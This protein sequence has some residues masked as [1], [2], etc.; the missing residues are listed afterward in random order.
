DVRLFL[1]AV[2]RFLTDG[3]NEAQAAVDIVLTLRRKGKDLLGIVVLR[4][5]PQAPSFHEHV[6]SEEDLPF[7]DLVGS[8]TE[9]ALENVLLYRQLSQAA[10]QLE[11][12]V[13]ERTCDLARSQEEL[14]QALT[15]REQVMGILGH[16]LRS[17]LSVVRMS[18]G[19]VLRREGLQDDI[20]RQLVRID[21]A[22]SRM[23]E[24]I[25]TLLDFTQSRFRANLPVSPESMDLHDVCRTVI[26]E[27]CATNPG[28]A[29][30]LLV[31]G[32]ARGW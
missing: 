12:K 15:F 20:K 29:I 8:H 2:T 16:D 6:V 25:G 4:K 13:A 10:Q 22:A 18:A 11:K 19:M 7:L 28:R 3:R 9:A 1:D 14:A 5:M 30:E 32:D 26:D 31:A 21:T 27:L 23:I 24:M 17:P